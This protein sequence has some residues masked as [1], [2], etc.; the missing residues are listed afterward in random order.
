MATYNPKGFAKRLRKYAENIPK[1]Q[2]EIKRELALEALVAIVG[3]TPVDTGRARDSWNV[4]AGRPDYSVPSGPYGPSAHRK[5]VAYGGP[6]RGGT[7][8]ITKGRNLIRSAR[9]KY[10]VPL[11]IASGLSY[12]VALNNGSSS[13]AP[14]NFVEIAIVRAR[15]IVRRQLRRYAAEI[16][17]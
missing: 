14:R 3:D 6:T 11:Y 16:W 9:V 13:Q 5:Q 4:S 2:N 17:K 12:M 1:Q 8:S 10:G 15:G 7:G